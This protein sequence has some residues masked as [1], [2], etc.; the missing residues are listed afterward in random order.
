MGIYESKGPRNLTWG[1]DNGLK[2]QI[3]LAQNLL[4]VA[5]RM[6]FFDSKWVF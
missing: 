5:L 6:A 3:K 1:R 4:E 2:L